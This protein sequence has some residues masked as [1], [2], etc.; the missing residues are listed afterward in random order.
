MS[1][2]LWGLG[3]VAVGMIPAVVIVWLI[4]NPENWWQRR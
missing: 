2:I 4:Y 1:N 3:G